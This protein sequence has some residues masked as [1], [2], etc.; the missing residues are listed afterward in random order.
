MSIASDKNVHGLDSIIS[1]SS[2]AFTQILTHPWWSRGSEFCTPLLIKIG[3]FRQT[4]MPMVIVQHTTK[5]WMLR[6]LN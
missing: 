5:H 3:R 4:L 6:S 2:C 1:N